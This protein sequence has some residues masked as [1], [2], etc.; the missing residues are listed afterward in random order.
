MPRRFLAVL[1]FVALAGCGAPSA[2]APSVTGDAGSALQRD[3]R[4]GGIED[5]VLSFS[6]LSVHDVAVDTR[7]RLLV[8]DRDNHRVAVLSPDGRL[9][10]TW[11][12]SGEGPGELQFPLT[13]AVAPDSTTHV[14]DS[15]K[16]KYVVFTPDGT[17][18]DE[19]AIERGRPFRFRFLPDGSIV[20]S[21]LNASDSSRLWR[22]SSGVRTPL[23]ALAQ[24]ANRET[25]PVCRVAGYPVAPIFTPSIAWDARDARTA[26]SVG[27]FA[28]TVYE[29][30]R[31]PRVLRRDTARRA[32]SR[33]LAA[34]MIG[35]GPTLQLQGMKP[36]TIPAEMVLEVAEVASEMPAY[37]ALTIDAKGTI[38]A[39][40]FT[41]PDEPA[42]AD[43]FDVETGFV[44]TIALG[45]ARP[46]AFLN[47]GRMVSIELDADE[48]PMVVV[49]TVSR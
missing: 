4:V 16:R 37:A 40:R 42:L 32:T 9:M 13:L 15:G 27:D 28:I 31:E 46:V 38:W 18:R 6:A 3:W 20:G 5:T 41:L 7:N 11:G 2:D 36:C 34:R 24:P 26:V 25:P 43:L 8:I 44:R 17:L 22:D 35:K 1:L 23:A 19:P 21:Q 33:E 49:Y 29:P 10:D 39:R 12:R 14:Y 48:V 47:D 30:G 45:A